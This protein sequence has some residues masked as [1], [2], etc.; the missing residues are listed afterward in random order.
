MEYEC[1]HRPACAGRTVDTKIPIRPNETYFRY[2]TPISDSATA[3]AVAIA[4]LQANIAALQK[5]IVDLPNSLNGSALC[6][7]PGAGLGLTVLPQMVIHKTVTRSDFTGPAQVHH[8]L[9]L[10]RMEQGLDGRTTR[11]CGPNWRESSPWGCDDNIK[12]QFLSLTNVAIGQLELQLLQ[13]RQGLRALLA[14]ENF[15]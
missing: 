7:V 11:S 10:Q 4:A 1:E 8:A 14:R 15:S 6:D 13:A 9:C 5:S 12:A 2:T 3:G